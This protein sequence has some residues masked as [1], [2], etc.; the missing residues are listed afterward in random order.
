MDIPSFA[1]NRTA[2]LSSSA[3]ASSNTGSLRDKAVELEGVFLNT[4]VSQMFSGL[5]AR[6][7]FGG[8]YAE[9]TWRSMQSELYASQLANNG[10]IGIADMIMP[11][12]LAIQ[13]AAGNASEL[14]AANAEPYSQTASDIL[15]NGAS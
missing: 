8:G 10:G 14:H 5:D 1:Q 9:E 12:L 7:A 6:G 13:E 3:T 2:Q 4:L 15:Q 11:D